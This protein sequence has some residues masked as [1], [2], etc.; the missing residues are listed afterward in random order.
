MS[1]MLLKCC[2]ALLH[3]TK[4]IVAF[5]H[6]RTLC[7]PVSSFYSWISTSKSAPAFHHDNTPCVAV[8]LAAVH[9][10]AAQI[11]QIL[12]TAPSA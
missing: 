9:L 8:K 10:D 4:L 3:L 2:A 5:L 1:C 11:A 12:K 6:L 7:C